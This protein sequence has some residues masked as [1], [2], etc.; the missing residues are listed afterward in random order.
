MMAGPVTRAPFLTVAF[1]RAWRDCPLLWKKCQQCSEAALHFAKDEACLLT[2]ALRTGIATP[3]TALPV[4]ALPLGC[5]TTASNHKRFRCISIGRYRER[6]GIERGLSRRVDRGAYIAAC[7]GI[8]GAIE[9][10]P[11]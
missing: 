2:H 10:A 11:V 9:N 6:E 1:P 8:G 3:N 4:A 5:F 7:Y